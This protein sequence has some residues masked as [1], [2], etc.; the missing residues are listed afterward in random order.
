MDNGLIRVGRYERCFNFGVGEYWRMTLSVTGIYEY[1]YI[2]I[3]MDDDV[4]MLGGIWAM[5]Y[6]VMVKYG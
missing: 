2:Y 3:Y 4:S 5:I 6:S 1:I